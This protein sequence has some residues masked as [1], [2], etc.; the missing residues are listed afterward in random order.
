MRQ[1]GTTGN[2]RMP[3][4]RELR[5]TSSSYASLLYRR[6]DRL[7]WRFLVTRLG[8]ALV[9]ACA[10]SNLEELSFGRL[11]INEV[12]RFA[13]AMAHEPAPFRASI[14]SQDV[15]DSASTHGCGGATLIFEQ[16]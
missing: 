5:R 11:I 16:I 8:M 10:L 15:E 9:R 13:P 7:N 12:E 2:L 4:M 3:R 14:R 1:I 6:H